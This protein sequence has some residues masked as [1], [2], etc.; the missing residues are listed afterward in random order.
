[1]TDCT[2]GAREAAP[3][4]VSADAMLAWQAALASDDGDGWEYVG[5]NTIGNLVYL[6]DLG[7]KEI[8]AWSMVG[9]GRFQVW[10]QCSCPFEG[11]AFPVESL[12]D[13]AARGRSI[14][15]EMAVY[16]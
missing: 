12:D 13:A 8:R 10:V 15:A 5:Q 3:E 11:H 7:D 2:C 1:M 6:L 9:D 16:T 4:L 14:C